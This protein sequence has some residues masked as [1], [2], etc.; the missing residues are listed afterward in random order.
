[1][2]FTT[3]NITKILFSDV[4]STQPRRYAYGCMLI[5]LETVRKE[6]NL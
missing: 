2:V 5:G 4:N 1:M 6:E 3:K